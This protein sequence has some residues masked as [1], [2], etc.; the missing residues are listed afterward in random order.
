MEIKPDKPEAF[1]SHLF[2]HLFKVLSNPFL[3]SFFVDQ[4]D[5]STVL[6]VYFDIFVVFPGYLNI[7]LII[8][9]NINLRTPLKIRV[10]C[11]KEWY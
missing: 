11:P 5:Q 6:V 3:G 10:L 7:D 8:P 9:V 4:I 1:I 2:M